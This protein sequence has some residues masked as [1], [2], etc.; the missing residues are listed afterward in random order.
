MVHVDIWYL[1]T[2]DRHDGVFVGVKRKSRQF[3]IEIAVMCLLHSM[4]NLIIKQLI[5]AQRW[6]FQII[7]YNQ[8]Q[9]NGR[10]CSRNY[11]MKCLNKQECKE[12]K[13]CTCLYKIYVYMTTCQLNKINRSFPYIGNEEM[14]QLSIYSVLKSNNDCYKMKV[15]ICV[16]N[17]HS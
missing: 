10:E 16:V 17:I 11:D 6:S 4:H 5:I 1:Y 2:G 8:V 7:I 14:Q 9:H 15:N 13:T 3:M 12:I